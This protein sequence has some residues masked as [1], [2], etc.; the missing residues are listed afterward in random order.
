MGFVVRIQWRTKLSENREVLSTLLY[1]EI[2]V[3]FSEYFS[4]YP[5]EFIGV[6]S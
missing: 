6:Y 3:E 4:S 1:V 2:E 5:E